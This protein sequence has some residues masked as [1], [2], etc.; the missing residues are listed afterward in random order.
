MGAA[1]SESLE[2]HIPQGRERKIERE[3]TFNAVSK[4]FFPLVY[5]QQQFE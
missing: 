1:D 4:L 3:I 5:F 2:E